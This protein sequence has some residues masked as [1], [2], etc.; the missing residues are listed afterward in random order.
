MRKRTTVKIAL[1]AGALATI[2]S[3]GGVASPVTLAH[4]VA[5]PGSA[6]AGYGTSTVRVNMGSTPVFHNLDL[7]AHDVVSDVP[8]WFSSVLIGVGKKAP[9]NGVALIVVPATYRFHCSIHLKM[10]GSLI[11]Q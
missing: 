6:Y 3:A 1:A 7:A 8:G 10:H 4:V 2:L 9:I 11:V 5:I